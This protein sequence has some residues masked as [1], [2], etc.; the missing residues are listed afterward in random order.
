MALRLTVNQR[1]VPTPPVLDFSGASG[2]KG[3]REE[4]FTLGNPK[5]HNAWVCAE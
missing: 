1:F 5:A 4:A 2:G 3:G